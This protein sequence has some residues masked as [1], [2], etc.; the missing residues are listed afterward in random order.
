MIS[1]AFVNGD[2][3]NIPYFDKSLAF[4]NYIESTSNELDELYN[5]FAMKYNKVM[6]ERSITESVLDKDTANELFTESENIVTKIGEAIINMAKKIKKYIEEL[7]QK[8]SGFYKKTDLE[9]LEAAIKKNPDVADPLRE[10]FTS[11]KLNIHDAKSIKEI[12]DAYMDLLKFAKRKDVD[13]KT[14][15]GKVEIFKDKCK[16]INDTSVVNVAK[17]AGAVISAAAAV[18]LFRKHF[19]DVKKA[20]LDTAAASE[21]MADQ[22]YEAI[23]DMRNSRD[24]DVNAAVD[25][26]LG[27]AQVLK[28]AYFYMAGEFEKMSTENNNFLEKLGRGLSASMRKVNALSGAADKIDSKLDAKSSDKEDEARRFLSLSG[29]RYDRRENRKSERDYDKA[30]DSNRAKKVVD[31]E[32]EHEDRQRTVKTEVEKRKAFDDYEASKPKPKQ[33]NQSN[34]G[35]NQKGKKRRK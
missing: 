31:D 14:L 34:V 26:S 24:A 29:E 8:A 21:K 5:T 32:F 17:G 23:T 6:V 22:L 16:K 13:P 3:E 2:V 20:Q 18:V 15:S 10:A 4:E 1:I 7:I 12:E 35:K 30:L 33:P 27:K 11:G 19:T 9:K 25:P 28:N